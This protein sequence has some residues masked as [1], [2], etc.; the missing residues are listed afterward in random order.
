MELVSSFLAISSLAEICV[1]GK[2][3]I[4]LPYPY[5]ADNHQ[6]HNARMVAGRGGALLRRESELESAGLAADILKIIKDPEEMRRMGAKAREVSF[7]G[8]S[9]FIV[10][11]CLALVG[12]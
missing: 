9:E 1:L 11:E 8:A 3:S 5:A 10:K 2:P 12:Q 7:P 4:L 6:E